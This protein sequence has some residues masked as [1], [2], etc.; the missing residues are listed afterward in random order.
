MPKYIDIHSHINFKVFDE[1]RSAVIHRALNGD[2]WLVNV[3]TQ[4]DTSKKAVEM[5]N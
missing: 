1:E 5:T 2:T 4:Y 3:G